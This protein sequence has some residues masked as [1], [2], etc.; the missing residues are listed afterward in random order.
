[1]QPAQHKHCV[2]LAAAC[3]KK[4]AAMGKAKKFRAAKV[5]AIKR[6]VNPKHDR[7]LKDKQDRGSEKK[8]SVRSRRTATSTRR[9]PPCSSRTTRAWGRPST[10]SL[11]HN[12]INF[13][14]KNKIDLVKGMTDCLLAKCVPVILD[15]VMAELEKLGTKYRLA[16]R[17]AG[18]ALSQRCRPI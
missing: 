17:L 13:S 8:R 12:F 15:S 16:L 4:F 2:T 7:R 5:R 6:T 3:V 10:S 18:T 9:R 1:M 14:I 11:I